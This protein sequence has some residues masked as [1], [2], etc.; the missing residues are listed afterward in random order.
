MK[1]MLCYSLLLGM[2][3]VSVLSCKDNPEP[4]T[5]SVDISIISP[6][7]N[8]A[9]AAGAEVNIHV[10]FSNMGSDPTI[11]NVKVELLDDSGASVDVLTDGHVHEMSG[12]YEYHNM[13]YTLPTAAGNY[14][15]RASSTDMMGMGNNE[16]SHALILQ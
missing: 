12:Y 10:N 5:Y 3:V 1:K 11:H 8:S 6:A 2:L 14:T 15:L 9:V 7:D 4:E 16:A 13:M